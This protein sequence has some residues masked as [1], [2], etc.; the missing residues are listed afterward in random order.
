VKL[1]FFIFSLLFFSQLN[2]E[3]NSIEYKIKAGYLYNFTK[4]ITWPEDE[5]ES[6]NL[7]ILGED[8]FGSILNP[9]E[10]RSVKGKPIRLSRIK[11]ADE[12][13][14]CHIV[15]ISTLSKAHISKLGTLTIK[16]VPAKLTVGDTK[17]F[18]RQDGMISFFQREGKVKLHINLPS[19]RKTGLEISA[20][21]LEVAEIYEGEQN[22]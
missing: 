9:I 16:S 2:A 8:P 13:K 12:A 10:K 17:E 5:L 7:C 19:L 1:F 15:Y 20:K 6:F 14:H 11:K 4:F 21:L 18:T 3:E 22:D